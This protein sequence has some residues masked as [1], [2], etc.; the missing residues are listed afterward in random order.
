MKVLLSG[1]AG[2]IGSHIVDTYLENGHEVVVIDNLSTGRIANINPEATFYK[3]DIRSQDVD[4][5]FEIERPDVVNHHAAQVSAHKSV[6]DPIGDA[7]INILGSLNLIECAIRHKTR[8][9]IYASPG[10]VL[11]GEPQY[12]PC[13]EAHPIN[14][15]CQHGAVNTLLNI[16]CTCITSIMV[17]SIR[18]FDIPTYTVRGKIS[19][20]IRAW[21]RFFRAKC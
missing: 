3:A 6:S 1:G 20:V 12:L 7:E 18:S 11:Y 14:P 5:I 13:D 19:K 15:T 9:F 21:W 16:I 4:N 8:R 17:C 2:F 10:L